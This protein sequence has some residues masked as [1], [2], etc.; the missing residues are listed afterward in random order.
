MWLEG[1]K[2]LIFHFV[3]EMVYEF[4]RST[5]SLKTHTKMSAEAEKDRILLLALDKEEYFDE[6]YTG[7]LTALKERADITEV[8]DVSTANAKLA[9]PQVN[10]KAIVITSAVIASKKSKNL[11]PKVLEYAKGGGRVIF[12][13][14]FSSMIRPPDF[15][16]FFGTV[17][18]L[19]WKFGDYNRTTFMLNPSRWN[20][21][22]RNSLLLPAYSMKA[23]HIKGSDFQSAVYITTPNSKIESNVFA[24]TS[25]HKAQA[26]V[27]FSPYYEGYVGYVGD[28]NSEK[29]STA[30]VLA[31]CGFEA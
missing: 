19:P 17:W 23:V 24:A 28:V 22:Q 25:A 16:K 4:T 2:R 9:S 31:M 6:I 3:K 27:V 29:G 20:E 10:W 13:G 1:P 15:D 11:H 30:V 26:P 18:S 7:L 21:L 8:N 12:A 5:T 14:T